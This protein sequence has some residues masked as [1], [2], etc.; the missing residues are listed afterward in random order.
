MLVVPSWIMKYY[1]LDLSPHNS[2]IRYLVD[3]GHTVFAMSWANPQADDRD[4]IAWE[5][6]V[7]A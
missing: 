7:H 2:L 3:Q 5:R 6:G 4:L 1:V